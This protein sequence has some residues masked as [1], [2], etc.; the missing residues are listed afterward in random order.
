MS[1]VKIEHICADILVVLNEEK[2]NVTH[3]ASFLGIDTQMN[4]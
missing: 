3:D 2:V 4:G 1:Q